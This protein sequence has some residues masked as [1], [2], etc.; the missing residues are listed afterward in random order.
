MTAIP[1][2]PVPIKWIPDGKMAV[3]WVCLGDGEPIGW[4]E[5]YCDRGHWKVNIELP[6]MD[7]ADGFPRYY[8]SESVAKAETEAFLKWR[9]WKVRT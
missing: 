8:M 9:L 6:D 7:G 2:T 3:E 4:K 5:P 1:K